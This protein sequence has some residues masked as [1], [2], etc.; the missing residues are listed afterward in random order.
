MS[1]RGREHRQGPS[2]FTLIELLVVI[3]IIAVLIALLLPAVQ[4]AREAARR[5]QCVNNLMQLSVAVQNYESAHELLPPGV[6]NPAGP[7]L[8][9]PKGYHMS[10]MV[11]I[12]PFIEQKNTHRGINFDQG[13]YD[14][15]NVTANA[16]VINT[17]LCP[18]D[19]GL[20]RGSANGVAQNSYAAN[21]HDVEAPIAANNNGVFFLNSKIRYDDITDGSAHTIFLGEKK[22]NG[23]DLGWGS[24]TRA[25]LRNTGRTINRP[26]VP[27]AGTIDG[28]ADDDGG[29]QAAANPS[30]AGFVG[31]YGSFH[32]GGS[33]FAFGDGSIKFLKNSINLKVF[34]ALGN[35]KDGEAISDDTY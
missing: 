34:Q 10:W 9:A 17:F 33:N 14:P 20:S 5:I 16:I 31:G 1:R 35:R 22:R 12:L 7:I 4:A 29:A 25:T 32:S 19:P 26:D 24:G 15:A 6:V 28:D 27:G 23:T 2:G 3:A 8:N 30:L 21:H 11:Q 18:S 13:I